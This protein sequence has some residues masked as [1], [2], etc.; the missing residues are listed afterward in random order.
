MEVETNATTSSPSFTTPAGGAVNEGGREGGKEQQPIT[1]MNPTSNII[2][3]SLTPVHANTQA[4]DEAFV[5]ANY[6]QL[7]PLM[8]KRMRQL[9]LQGIATRLNYSSED[10]DEERELEASPGFRTRPSEG[11]EEPITRNIPLLLAAHLRETERGQGM[12]PLGGGERPLPKGAV[13]SY[14]DLKKRFRTY[15]NQQKKQTKTYLAIN[16]IKR[17][18]GESVRAFISRYRNETAQ[19]T[20]LNED[21]RIA[22]FVHGVKIKSLVKFVCAELSESYDGLIDKAYS[23]LQAEETASEGQPITF[24]D[25][26]IGEKPPRGK[27]WKGVGRKNKEKRHRYNPYKEASLGILQNLTKSREKSW[28]PKK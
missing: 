17:R 9:R 8:R 20:K 25:G 28:P 19:I 6:S 16:G 14:E 1:P 10:V 24:M 7:E 3:D 18:E 15:F 26:G 13:L 27:P 2:S 23:W 21:Q 5:M 12:V 22:G 11:R 4:I